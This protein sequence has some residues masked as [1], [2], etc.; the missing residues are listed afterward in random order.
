M[1]RT[2]DI[3]YTDI[4]TN[5]GCLTLPTLVFLHTHAWYWDTLHAQLSDRRRHSNIE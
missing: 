3:G 4:L 1:N 2:I 5:G